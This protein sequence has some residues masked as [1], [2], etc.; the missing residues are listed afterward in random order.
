MIN[1]LQREGQIFLTIIMYF[2]F[3]T[4][5]IMTIKQVFMHLSNFLSL[6]GS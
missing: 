3:S 6:G 2:F 1:F 5:L 4:M